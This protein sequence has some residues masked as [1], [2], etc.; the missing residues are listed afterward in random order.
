MGSV[1][2]LTV[3]IHGS[4]RDV[5]I[6]NPVVVIFTEKLLGSPEND[7]YENFRGVTI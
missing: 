7:Q 1:C 6:L 5:L 4:V 2:S 3:G